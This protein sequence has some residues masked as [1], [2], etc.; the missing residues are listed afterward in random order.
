VA[1][2]KKGVIMVNTARGGLIDEP[3][4]LAAVQSGQVGMA[5]L[6]SVAAEPMNVPHIFHHQHGFIL[7]PHIGGVT[8]DAYIYMGMVAARNTLAVLSAKWISDP[9]AFV[10][11]DAHFRTVMEQ[12]GSADRLV[13]TFTTNGTHSYISDPT[14]PA[15]MAALL[16]WIEQGTKPTAASIATACPSFE[17][18][19]GS[20]CSFAPTNAPSALETRVPVRERP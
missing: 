2:C 18:K 14:Y 8:G 12:G 3:A 7:S 10:E 5:A 6:D 11:L 19:F 15:L 4:L 1:Q 16:Q 20:G 17:A 13:Q 9:T